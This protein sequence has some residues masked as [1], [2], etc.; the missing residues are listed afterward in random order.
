MGWDYGSRVQ[1]ADR[2][3][4]A[5]R[6]KEDTLKLISLASAILLLVTCVA[7]QTASPAIFFTDLTS[8]PNAGG[9]N[10]SGYAGAYVTIYGNNFGSTQGASTVTWN[11]QSCLRVVS[12]G[13][14]YLWYQRT[15]VQLG[16]SCTPGTGKFVVTVNGQASTDDTS[17]GDTGANFTVESGGNIYCVSTSGNDSS[18][19]GHFPSSC[20]L[21]IP[22]AKDTMAA[23]DVVYVENGVSQTT[24]DQY[25]ILTLPCGG[26]SWT[27]P[28]SIVVYPGASATIGTSGADTSVRATS[29]GCGPKTYVTMAGFHLI[30]LNMAIAL[31]DG[32]YSGSHDFRFVANDITCPNGSGSTACYT[33]NF[34]PSVYSYG[35]NVHGAGYSGSI[36]TYHSV[37]YSSDDNHVWDAWNTVHDSL[38]CRGI[39][40][41]STGASAQYDL[42]VHDDLIY[43]IRCDG[44]NFATVDPS[45][46]T[47]EAYNNVIYHVGTGPDPSDGP[48]K[49]DCIRVAG[50]TTTATVKLYNNTLYDCGR[51]G[52]SDAGPIMVDT[53]MGTGPSPNVYVS[54]NIIQQVSG[55]GYTT[56][57]TTCSQWSGGKN[58]WYGG[59][60][61]PPCSLS[62][63]TTAVNPL[64]VAPTSANFHL[65]SG[66][67]AIGAGSATL[68]P[69]H[70]HDG[71]IRSQPPSIGAYEFASS[72]V[73][74][75]SPPT[76]L[77]VVVN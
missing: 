76:N 11:G 17:H 16:S 12:W 72:S 21:T 35:N 51:I 24:T 50:N 23:G 33:D 70:D 28:K 32:L 42:H 74:R 69:N 1:T 67:P 8:A 41:F 55:E 52:G 68:F 56:G 57:T 54:N 75:P 2:P 25:A 66:S 20:W 48:A 73:T 77:T 63:D 9:E 30:A 31:D 71:L 22:H 19:N 7:A 44:L 37:Y 49:Y 65:Q 14:S 15:V 29:L 62:G 39:Q 40:F 64:L 59:S 6:I 5:A 26:T 4:G 38:A 18:N 58:M 53:S 13:Q 34:M 47:V 3:P 27:A 36:K 10:V 43:N 45:V 46:A 61:S 60:G